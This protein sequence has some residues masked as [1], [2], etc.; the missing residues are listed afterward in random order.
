MTSW[1]TRAVLPIFLVR[2]AMIALPLL[3]TSACATSRMGDA[4]VREQGGKPCFAPADRELERSEIEWV[5]LY[6]SDLSQR[7]AKQG[8]AVRL[9]PPGR[10]VR[11]VPGTCIEYGQVI[12]ES[13]GTE[14]PALNTD[15]V[16]E[17]FINGRTRDPYDSTRGYIAKFCWLK[18]AN[19]KRRLLQ[20]LPGTPGWREDTCLADR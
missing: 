5:G 7:P 10:K 1:R 4:A 20:L 14:P 9:S 3:A 6:V 15:H 18:D 17:V 8:W 19:G 13:E 12:P 2:T 11:V 16:Y